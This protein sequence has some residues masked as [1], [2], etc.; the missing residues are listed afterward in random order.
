MADR[1][2]CGWSD[3][4]MEGDGMKHELKIWPQYFERVRDGSKTFEIRKN[5][6]GFQFGDEV[7]LREYDPTPVVKRDDSPLGVEEWEEPRGYT[8]KSLEF[9]I[10]YVLPVDEERVVFSLVRFKP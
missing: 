10:G 8:G 7:V 4:R 5:D 2:R 6:R 9:K 3:D 1:I